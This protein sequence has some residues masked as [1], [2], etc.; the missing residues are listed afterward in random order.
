MTRDNHFR[1]KHITSV[2]FQDMDAGGHVHHS[3]A[4]SYFEEDR[5]AYWRSVV[6]DPWNGTANYVIAES[7][8]KY[9]KRILYPT[10]IEVAV[11]VSEIGRTSLMMEYEGMS[12]VGDLLIS[13]S[14]FLVMF[15]YQEEL[16]V[17]VPEDVKLAIVNWENA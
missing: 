13:G 3:V 10:M 1:F 11:R 2:R 8:V 17:R 12:E 6:G 4:L 7:D 14:T 15:D 5:E 16:P 9:H